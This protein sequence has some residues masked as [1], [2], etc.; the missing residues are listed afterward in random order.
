MI[1]CEEDVQRSHFIVIVLLCYLGSD[2]FSSLSDSPLQIILMFL[3]RV[4]S[5]CFVLLSTLVLARSGMSP[6]LKFLF[7]FL[8]LIL[9]VFSSAAL[10]KIT[11]LLLWSI[12]F[13]S[14]CLF[15]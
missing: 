11:V 1:K 8:C 13:L 5:G 6:L 4:A 10:M 9:L 14:L 3:P 12:I 2:N 7:S 15:K